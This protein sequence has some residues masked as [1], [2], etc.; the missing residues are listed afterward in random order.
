[1]NKKM[2]I[3]KWKNV[4]PASIFVALEGLSAVPA[5]AGDGI[6][7]LQ[8][9]VPVRPAI[10]E[11]SPGRAVTI[12][13]SPNDKVQQ[14]VGQSSSIMPTE[15]T[16]TDFAAISTGTPKSLGIASDA[17]SLADIG[18]SGYGLG[19]A[20]NAGAVQSVSPMI[21]GAVGGAVGAATGQLSA[22]LTGASNPMTGL[23]SAIMRTSG[24]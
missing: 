13:T 2:Y 15:L 18:M 10:R 9:E 20:G 1:M 5:I 24:Q 12:D 16:D 21:A 4:I 8:R 23:T 19:V 7:V 6:V 17:S 11:G 3:R 22:G 14:A